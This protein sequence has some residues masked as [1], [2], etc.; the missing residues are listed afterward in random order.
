MDKVERNKIIDALFFSITFLLICWGLFLSE[1]YLGYEIKRWGMRPRELKGLIGV[2]SMHFLHGDYKHIWG[3]TMSFF[4]LNSF[5]FYF[6]RKI[7]LKVFLYMFF[8]GAILLW[9]WGR[10]SN[11]IGASLL[12]F[13]LAAFM[14]F[15]GVFRDN[16]KLLRVALAVAFYYGS[17]VW[18]VLPIDPKISW[19]GHLSGAV[20]GIACA[21]FFRG[22]GPKRKKYQWEIDE[23]LESIR[24]EEEAK[25]VH[26]WEN[27]LDT[28]VYY[29]IIPNEEENES[30]E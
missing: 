29:E 14:F 7:A 15:S 30:G 6:Y 23:E 16:E 17:I 27:A 8:F 11:H 22:D 24:L 25:R 12:I 4:I 18:L 5:L 28:E 3:N 19:E 20:V 13:A 26:D 2:V 10:P 9:F 21:W 1:E